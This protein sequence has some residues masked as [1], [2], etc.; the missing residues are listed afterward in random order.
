[1]YLAQTQSANTKPIYV[2]ETVTL[3]GANDYIDIKI[4]LKK[5]KVVLWRIR[6]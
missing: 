4:I 2:K 3:D 5:R 6:I 1:M